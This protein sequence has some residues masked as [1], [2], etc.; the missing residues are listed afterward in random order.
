MCFARMTTT[1]HDMD[2]LYAALPEHAD[3]F[4][5]V[6]H[7]WFGVGVPRDPEPSGGRL[8][9]TAP[10]SAARASQSYHRRRTLDSRSNR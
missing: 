3:L 5:E 1:T 9:V 4:H 10:A 8:P 6:T 2:L 7:P